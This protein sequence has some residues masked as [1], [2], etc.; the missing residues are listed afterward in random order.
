MLKGPDINHARLI[1]FPS[2]IFPLNLLTLGIS[3]II[4][5]SKGDF[6]IYQNSPRKLIEDFEICMWE[7]L[8]GTPS[9]K[10]QGKRN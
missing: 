2:V 7:M 4:E 10:E 9:R 8:P 5:K 1:E 6:L 3:R